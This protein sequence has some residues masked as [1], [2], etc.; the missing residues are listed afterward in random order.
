MGIS[1]VENVRTD[2]YHNSRGSDGRKRGA[3][4]F[5]CAIDP[6]ESDSH[7]DFR[8]NR[9]SAYD[10]Y[11]SMSAGMGSKNPPSRFGKTVLSDVEF[12]PDSIEPEE[13]LKEPEGQKRQIQDGKETKS[14]IVVRPDGSRVLMITVSVGGMKA[15]TSVEISEPTEG[16]IM[17]RDIRD[18]VDETPVNENPGS[19]LDS[20]DAIRK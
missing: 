3:A 15:V 7:R 1:G 20:I 11:C 9:L 5:G 8:K 17:G 4:L 16:G 12:Q 14:E 19:T 6:I 13:Q 18:T 10:A 2:A